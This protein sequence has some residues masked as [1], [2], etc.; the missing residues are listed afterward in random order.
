MANSISPAQRVAAEAA[1]TIIDYQEWMEDDFDRLVKKSRR[2]TSPIEFLCLSVGKCSLDHPFPNLDEARQWLQS[3]RDYEAKRMA[4]LSNAEGPFVPSVILVV[5]DPPPADLKAWKEDCALREQLAKY[6]ALLLDR[7]ESRVSGFD[8]DELFLPTIVT[9]MND[10]SFVPQTPP[11]PGFD[12]NWRP[13]PSSDPPG[14][15]G[16][17]PSSIPAPEQDFKLFKKKF[18]SYSGEP[19][20]LEF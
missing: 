9:A 20:D 8:D 17:Q 2:S 11:G 13:P 5:T 7:P 1:R 18:E 19:R 16:R 14:E 15:Y 10:S 4:D 12:S 3:Y 6:G